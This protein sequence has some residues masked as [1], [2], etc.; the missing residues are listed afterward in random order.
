MMSEE[1]TLSMAQGLID[2]ANARQ[3]FHISNYQNDNDVM[4]QTERSEL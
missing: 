3:D 4:S 1:S 2:I